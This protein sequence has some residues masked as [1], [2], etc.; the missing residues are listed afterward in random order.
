M[1]TTATPPNSSED[2]PTTKVEPTSKVIVPKTKVTVPLG[3]ENALFRQACDTLDRALHEWK[4]TVSDFDKDHNI[5]GETII[6]NIPTYISETVVYGK[7]V[8][9]DQ[10]WEGGIELWPGD[11]RVMKLRVPYGENRDDSRLFLVSGSV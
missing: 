1:A 10:Y 3:Q 8:G 7:R 4:T 2:H 6:L 5:D 11:T 9:K